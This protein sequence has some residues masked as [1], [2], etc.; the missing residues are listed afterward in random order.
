MQVVGRAD[1]DG[2]DV[3]AGE[4][5]LVGMVHIAVSQADE[6][7]GAELGTVVD[8]TGRGHVD[9]S[10]AAHHGQQPPLQVPRADIAD[11]D[12]SDP[13]TVVGASDAGSLR[14]DGTADEGSTR[15]TGSAHGE[16]ILS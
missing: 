14:S 9:G 13:D 5:V 16:F 2:I 1:H 15:Q 11:A 12:D 7:L 6:F 8:V 4:Q 3:I 10:V